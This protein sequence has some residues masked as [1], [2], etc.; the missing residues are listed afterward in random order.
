MKNS[1]V[2]PYIDTGRETFEVIQPGSLTTVQ[3]LGRFGYQQY[4]VPVAGAMDNYALRIANLLT[5]NSE[6]AAAL[7][8]TLMG[9]K[10]RMLADTVIAVTG[11]DLSSK[12][13]NY[14][15]PMW[16]SIAVKA[17]DIISFGWAKTGCR[18]YL[19]V[20]GGINVPAVMGSGSTYAKSGIGGF[21]GRALMAGD[22]L[23]SGNASAFKTARKLPP[24]FIPVFAKSNTIRVILGPQDDSFTEEGIMTFLAS[25][26]TISN[27][28][29]R[30]GYRLTGPTIKHK[31]GADI[32]SDG[33]PAGAIQVPGS[34]LPIVL[35]A[36]R[37]T[38]GG[39]PK[40]ACVITAD[41]P[42][43]AQAKPGDKIRFEGISI[44]K[45]YSLLQEYVKKLAVIREQLTKGG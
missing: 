3:D 23:E 35:L 9:L 15:L 33:I 13:N 14:L 42:K 32:I 45:A 5:G 37:Q 31:A 10:L 30:T 16:Q 34:G 25:E 21:K 12:I 1:N 28:A 26:Y 7:E 39:Y 2:I 24:E 11:G 41:I 36:D 8:I 44:D 22:R 29:D 17:G 6:D 38:T 18:A 20:A 27:E 43:L 40:I 19:A 4:G